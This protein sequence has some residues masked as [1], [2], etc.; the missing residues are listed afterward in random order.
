M[1]Y[2][3][4]C[5]AQAELSMI[6]TKSIYGQLGVITVTQATLIIY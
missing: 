4:P 5:L 1:H 6:D 3:I 2:I